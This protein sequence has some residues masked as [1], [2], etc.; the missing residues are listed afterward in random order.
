MGGGE[1]LLLLYKLKG[2]MIVN[3]LFT[4]HIMQE[5]MSGSE[6]DEGI[7]ERRKISNSIPKE[8][9]LFPPAEWHPGSS[10]Y[11]ERQVRC[12]T[13]ITSCFC[14]KPPPPLTADAASQPASLAPVRLSFLTASRQSRA[15]P[16]R[17]MD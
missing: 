1:D 7:Q 4:C 15:A 17:A 8:R 10:K 13:Y 3:E 9:T 14:P 6:P 5:I 12:K 2:L 16:E 11:L